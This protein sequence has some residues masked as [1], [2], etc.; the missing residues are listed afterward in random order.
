MVEEQQPGGAQLQNQ[1][2][3]MNGQYAEDP[4]MDREGEEG[5]Q[6]EHY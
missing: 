1:Q 3:E 4:A 2:Q 5:E 6:V